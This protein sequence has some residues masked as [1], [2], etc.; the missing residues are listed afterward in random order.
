MAI[1]NGRWVETYHDSFQAKLLRGGIESIERPFRDVA[2]TQGF[3]PA[4]IDALW[5]KM[6]EAQNAMDAVY[7]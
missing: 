3:E 5:A 7:G 2:R 6:V 4:E 1:V